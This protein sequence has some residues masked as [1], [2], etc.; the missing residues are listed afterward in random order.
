M[1]IE[2]THSTRLQHRALPARNHRSSRQIHAFRSCRL[3][4][5]TLAH[6]SPVS[7]YS[8]HFPLMIAAGP[9]SYLASS[10]VPSIPLDLRGPC[11]SSAPPSHTDLTS[12][13]LPF[14]EPRA[15]VS[16]RLVSYR[17]CACVS[18]YNETPPF[19]V[20]PFPPHDSPHS[21]FGSPKRVSPSA[22]T[23]P[24]RSPSSRRGGGSCGTHDGLLHRSVP[25][26][27]EI[28]GRV[29]VVESSRVGPFTCYCS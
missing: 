7:C 20:L 12:E 28:R 5:Y 19:V 2:A 1:M 3:D 21:F 9:V 25:S 14:R 6:A 22:H 27:T 4:C 16:T 11:R 29:R 15:L 17:L 24:S 18:P 26:P 8:S 23:L 10:Y 13:R